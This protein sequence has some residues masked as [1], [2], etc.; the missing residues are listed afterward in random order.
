M[1]YA[2]TAA[3][4]TVLLLAGT[5]AMAVT[6]AQPNSMVHIGSTIR[7]LVADLDVRARHELETG[8]VERDGQGKATL[9]GSSA[10]S[11]D[12]LH[13]R[14]ADMIAEERGRPAAQREKAKDAVRSFTG[15]GRL[16][17]IYTSTV[18]NPYTD[19]DSLIETYVDDQ[20]NEYW[21]NPANEVVVQIGAYA[22][23]RPTT[24]QIRPD[25][26]RPV[27]DLR[28]SAL[29]FVEREIQNFGSRKKSFVPL[30]DNKDGQIYF[31]RWDDFSHPAKE[32]EMPP[33]IQVGLFADGTLASY[34]NTLTR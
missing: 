3:A 29:A 19:D 16:P 10:E 8:C 18:S 34:T 1:R 31:F 33:F 15:K 28:K 4:V 11:V 30:E 7:S 12:A 27:A 32:S 20:G 6:A 14:I 25:A 23:A 5:S 26:R 24:S 2:K 17:L 21:V 9:C 22:G 13:D